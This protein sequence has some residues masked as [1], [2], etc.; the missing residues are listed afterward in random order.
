MISGSKSSL[1]RLS[2]YCLPK[3]RA[4]IFDSQLLKATVLLAETPQTL[5]VLLFV[6]DVQAIFPITWKMAHPIAFD[7]QSSFQGAR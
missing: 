3:K 2:Q 6:A 5:V 4:Y 1:L 7:T